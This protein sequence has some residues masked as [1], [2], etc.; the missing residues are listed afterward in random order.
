[1]L[2][3]QIR[4]FWLQLTGDSLLAPATGILAAEMWGLKGRH[5]ELSVSITELLVVPG[6]LDFPLWYHRHA[7]VDL[8]VVREL[9]ILIHPMHF[10]IAG[11][12]LGTIK[13]L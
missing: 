13:P 1:M 10:V 7:L 5:Q 4:N 9:S 2:V 3:C 8:Q 12:G 11:M 6:H